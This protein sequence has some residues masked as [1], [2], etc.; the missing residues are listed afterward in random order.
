MGVGSVGG[1]AGSPD[2]LG[3]GGGERV[4]GPRRADQLEAGRHAVGPQAHRHGHAGQVEEVHERLVS[5]PSRSLAPLGSAA[6]S[7]RRAMPGVVGSTSASITSNTGATARRS[8]A[9]RY[10][11]V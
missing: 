6:T 5:R 1:G 10:S 8:S 3:R 2:E 11:V 9:S 4:V 7:A